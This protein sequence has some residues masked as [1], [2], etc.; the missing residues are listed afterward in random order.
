MD[1]KDYMRAQLA[2]AH[3]LDLER[4][5]PRAALGFATASYYVGDLEAAEIGVRLAERLRPGHRETLRAA[6]LIHSAAGLDG[7]ARAVRASLSSLG[8]SAEDL[9]HIDRRMSQWGDIHR[10]LLAQAP[11]PPGQQQPP[12]I[13]QTS[14][15]QGVA[16]GTVVAAHWADCGTGLQQAANVTPTG[17]GIDETVSL[18]ALPSPCSGRP[19]PRMIQLDATFIATGESVESTSKGVNLL[20]GLQVVFGASRAFVSVV[21]TGTPP[22]QATTTNRSVGLPQAGVS[23]SLNIA[24]AADLR[25]DV[26]ARPTCSRSTACPPRF[27]RAPTCRSPSPA[28]SAAETWSTSRSAR[29]CR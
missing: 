20:Q 12:A 29:A 17:L 3:V 5:D 18:N 24:N 25:A 14:P 1:T 10:T 6:A 23:Y 4:D 27:S 7:E 11:P 2:Y 28:T 8:A 19:L 21:T 15:I 9:R 13:S 16:P 22:T 26:L